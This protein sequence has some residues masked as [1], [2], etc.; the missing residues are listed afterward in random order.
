MMGSGFDDAYIVG[1]STFT[2]HVANSLFND[3]I[4]TA[5]GTFVSPNDVTIDTAGDSVYVSGN[6]DGALNAPAAP[7]QGPRAWLLKFNQNLALQWATNTAVT[8]SVG[9]PV[10]IAST[11]RTI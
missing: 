11:T 5:A 4:Q 9:T 3:F 6:Y 2:G 1:L 8:P 10:H 7:Y